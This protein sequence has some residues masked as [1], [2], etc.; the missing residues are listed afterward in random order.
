MRIGVNALYLIP[1][2]VGGTEIYLRN[3][4]RELAD[5]DSGNEYFVYVNRETGSDLTPRRSNFQTVRTGVR[6]SFRPGRILWEQIVLPVK[7]WH[8]RLD[9]LLNPGFTT[10]ILSPSPTVTVFHDLQHKRHPEHFRWF[11]LPFWRMLLYASARRSSRLLADSRETR[12]DLLR[13]Y[14]LPEEKVEV[15]PL[16]VEPKFFEIGRRRTLAKSAA[17]FILA[18]STLHPH[19]NL[20]GL[21]KAFAEFRMSQPEFRLVIAGLRGFHAEALEELS[22]SLGLE[23]CVQFTGWIPRDE[24]YEC[25]ARAHAFIYPSTFEGFG[26]PV[27]EALAAG[28]PTAVS[29]I[30]PVSG[31]AASAALQFDPA[32]QPE[33]V[34]ALQLLVSDEELRKRL[35][36]AGPQRARLFSWRATAERTLAALRRAAESPARAPR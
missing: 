24:L 20:G 25:F 35:A 3:L 14:A 7:V 36:A 27:L 4:L 32:S 22:R 5:I 23:E 28:I 10:P 29:R 21:L 26:L 1:G 13:F 19:K 16:G 11:D 12:S 15:V 9:V 34:E 2:R 30:E 18:V 31:I 6:A 17:P 8:H 33:M